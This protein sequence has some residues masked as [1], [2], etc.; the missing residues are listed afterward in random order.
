MRSPPLFQVRSLF[1]V[2]FSSEPSQKQ[3]QPLTHPMLENSVVVRSGSGQTLSWG[4]SFSTI[5]PIWLASRALILLVLLG[6]APLLPTPPEA[7]AVTFSWDVFSAWDSLRYQAIATLGYDFVPGDGDLNNIVFFPLFPFLVGVLG[8]LG[9]PFNIAGTLLNSGAF[10]AALVVLYRWVAEEKGEAVAKW[11]VMAM[12][13][14]PFS[15]YGT[16][17]YTEGLFL[18]LTVAALFCFD[19]GQYRW[20]GLWG[21]MATATRL[22]AL[23]LIPTFLWVTWQQR[24]GPRALAAALFSGWGV[25]VFSLYCWL[26]FE[27][28]LAYLIEQKDWTRPGDVRGQMWLKQLAQVLIGPENW[29]KGALVNLSHPLLVALIAG[30][31]GVCG[32]MAR[33]PRWRTATNAGFCVLALLLWLIAGSPLINTLMVLGGSYLLWYQRKRLNPLMLVYGV[34]GFLI[35]YAT[36]R[37]M[38]VERYAYGIV[39]LA[40]ALGLVL[41]RY[42]RSGLVTLVFFAILL[43]T[44]SLKFAQE[45]WV[46]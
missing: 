9:L 4:A 23:A 11:S 12:A 38:S 16:V 7:Q 21:A 28:P 13:W 45:F 26:R 8:L 42:P 15:I 22:P 5:L 1:R 24:R 36:G 14:C 29:D 43:V 10:L 33:S 30:L 41:A 32:W 18:F 3:G 31:A 44:F 17:I 25:A 19:R 6:I 46:A 2:K 37:T 20:A 27:Q 40:P 39:S 35:I 34:F